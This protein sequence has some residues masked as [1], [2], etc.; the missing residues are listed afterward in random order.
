MNAIFD[1]KIEFLNSPHLLQLYAGFFELEKKGVTRLKFTHENK[2]K[3]ALAI[4]TVIVNDK[5]KVIYD[6]LDGLSWK[7]GTKEENLLHFRK[8]FQC[9]FYF[10]RSYSPEMQAY[11]PVGCQ[12]LPLGFNYNIQPEVNLMPYS[13]T[14]KDK[15]IYVLKTN[16]ITRLFFG[17]NFFYAKDFEQDPVSSSNNK[18][19]FITRL[20]NPDEA[21]SEGSKLH[22]QRINEMRVSCIQACR[23]KYKDQFTG[24]L[25]VDAYTAKKYPHLGMPDKLT[26]KKGYLNAIQQHAI[27]IATTGLHNSIGWKMAEYVAASKAIVSEPLHFELPGNFEKNKN[28]VE[29]KN[30]DELIFQ[31]DA[32]LQN[33]GMKQEMMNQ[34]HY[35]YNH[36]LKPDVLVLNTLNKVV[37][38]T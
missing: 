20:W 34:N 4:A 13:P 38:N 28:Y 29:F 21:L 10:K 3:N 16:P 14:L 2:S 33:P 23:E 18:I 25:I 9:D 35:Y 24:G 6:T 26:N 31:I 12:V 30:I 32:L 22:R 15:V 8:S 27:C 11:A 36:F 17:K 7:K 37:A 5:Y 1:C 19:L